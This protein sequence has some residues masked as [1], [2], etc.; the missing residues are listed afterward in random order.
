MKRRRTAL[1]VSVVAVGLLCGLGIGSSPVADGAR[2]SAATVSSSRG[3]SLA[4]APAPPRG[5]PNFSATFSGKKLNTKVWSTCFPWADVPAGCTNFGN[6]QEAEWYLPGQ[7]RVSGGL[8]HLVAQRQKTT[9][10]N[11]AGQYKA[12]YCRSGMITSFPSLRFKYGFIQI[13]AKIPH[14]A[15]LWPAI[16]LSAANLRYPPEMDIVESWGVKQETAAFLHPSPST[17]YVRS[18]DRALIPVAWTTNWQTYTLR[19]TTSKVT[20]Y[21]GTRAV[22]TVTKNIPHQDMYLIANVAEYL[23][24]KSGLCNGQ[25]EIKSVKYWKA[26]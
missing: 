24:A 5:K 23:P 8:L 10:K 20:Y 1:G 13:V 4:A 16:W 2:A 17:A 3:S 9:G 6:K 11:S 26:A 12:Y 21:I 14:A 22:L 19:W 25:M 15:G 7:D 18:R